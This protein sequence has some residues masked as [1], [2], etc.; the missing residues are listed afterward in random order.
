MPRLTES[1][2]WPE[3]ENAITEKGHTRKR[4]RDY[5]SQDKTTLGSKEFHECSIGRCFEF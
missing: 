5:C 2:Q 4:K 3:I 1:P